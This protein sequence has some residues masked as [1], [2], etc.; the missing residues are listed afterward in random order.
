MRI[1][2][3]VQGKWIDLEFKKIKTY[4]RYTRYQV[5]KVKGNEYIPLYTECFSN[6]QLLELA[7]NRFTITEEQVE[8]VN[9]CLW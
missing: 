4:P 3:K 1:K 8:E 2:K 5:Y 6:L 9:L 7:N